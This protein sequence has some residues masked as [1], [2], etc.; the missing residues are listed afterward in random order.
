M[1]WKLKSA[2]QNVVAALPSAMSYR[3]YYAM[4]KRFGGYRDATP[5]KRLA[6][7][8]ELIRRIEAHG[9]Q[10]EGRSFVEV[11]T[12][13]QVN[14]PIALYL[15][16][17]GR[18]LTVDLHP[19]LKA[20]LVQ[21][22]VAYILANEDL[23]QRLFRPLES[24]RAFAARFNRLAAWT[25]A[26]M[27]SLFDAMDIEYRAP[28]D[29]SWLPL[30]AGTVDYHVSFTV[31]EHIPPEPLA[32]I[33][34]EARRVLKPGGLFAHYVDFSD[35]FSHSDKHISPVNFLQ[36]GERAWQLYGGNRYMYQN[37]LRVDD[38]LE[39]LQGAGLEPAAVERQVDTWAL[40]L[41]ASGALPVAKR[42]RT[43]A[44]EVN[45]TSGAWI[46]ARPA[47]AH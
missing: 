1:H 33:L 13:H 32:A 47:A 21:Q 11:G 39:L 6:A 34:H 8:V 14:V 28:A 9:G 26:S 7:G 37:R 15:A 12:G 25:G 5:V 2:V 45:A 30:P 10:I 18:I 4:Q 22:D 35:H 31:L 29:A 42:F 24:K 46:L 36:F 41:L 16:G 40:S 23:V 38:V 19:Y 20:E 44:P 27:T 3:V 43:K 17:A